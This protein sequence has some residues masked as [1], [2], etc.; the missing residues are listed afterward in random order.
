LKLTNEWLTQY[1][2]AFN[3][4]YF[5]TKLPA[6]WVCFSKRISRGSCALTEFAKG[7]NRPIGIRVN[8]LYQKLGFARDIKVTLLHEMLHVKLGMGADPKRH[9]CD[10]NS[11]IEKKSHRW[12]KEV[13]KLA[14][15]GAFDYLI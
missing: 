7:T 14:A 8:A 1:Y 4:D 6:I 15:L 3:A 12:R 9:S 2:T 10:R 13:R 11:P 5:Q